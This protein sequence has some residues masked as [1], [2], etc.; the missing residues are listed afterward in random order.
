MLTRA[1][2]CLRSPVVITCLACALLVAAAIYSRTTLA[3][4]KPATLARD[5]QFDEEVQ[6]M[7]ARLVETRRDFHMHPELSNHEER[8]SGIVADRLR[9]LGFE[10]KTGVAR[11]GV[12][13]LLRG[14]RPGGVVAIRADMD[15][16]PINEVR[17]TPYKSQNPGVMHACGHDIH[18]TVALG[19]A[20]LLSKHRD[21]IA[22]AVKFIFQPAEEMATDAPEWGAKLMVKEGALENPRPSAIFGLHSSS[23]LEAGKIGYSENAVT[24]S[25]DTFSIRIRG[26]MTHGA[27]PQNGADAIVVAS[28]AVM[29][30]Q[31]IRSRRTDT[32]DP[33]VLTIG[34]FHGGN[35]ENIVAEEVELKGTVR[36]Y[37]EPVQ[38]QVIQ[39]MHQTLKGVT[40]SFGASY[41]LDYKKGY[42]PTINNAVLVRRMLPM[43]KRVAGDGNVSADP[44]SMGG[45]DFSYFAKEIPGFF[46]WLGVANRA[47]GITSGPHT[48]DFDADEKCIITGVKTMAAMVCDY[49]EQEAAP[50]KP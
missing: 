1:L 37:S 14:N 46:Y 25:A 38:D 10:V 49:L 34:S 12:I 21:R 22:G 40:E 13:G 43:M 8:T 31:T 33:L 50:A 18:T 5:A 41:V 7:F 20:E 6:E 16:L 48:P 30:L 27:Y 44:P 9:A 4:D 42:P 36:T 15:A 45:E 24:A 32:L 39:L 29:Q 47:R 26:K 19:V 23:A 17:N 35:R 28:A 11:H 2:G 3:E